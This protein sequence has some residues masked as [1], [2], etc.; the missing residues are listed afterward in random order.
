MNLKKHLKRTAIVVIILGILIAAN[1]AYPKINETVRSEYSISSKNNKEFYLTAHRGLS[2]V[3]PENTDLAILEAGIAGYYAAEF[4][5][6][7]TKDGRW[8]LMHDKT[9]D[10]MTNGE[11]EVSSFTFDE[12]R[13]LTVDG[14]NRS[15][16]HPE[17]III[18]TLEEALA[19]CE[20]YSMRAMIEI[21]GGEPEDMASVLEII[22]SMNLQT[23]PLIID[24]NSDRLDA[25]R[26][27]DRDIELWYLVSKISDGDIEF[28]KEHNT[29][30]AFNHKKFANYKM[31]GKAKDEGIKLAAWTVDLLPAADIL[32]ALGVKYITT[33][34]ILP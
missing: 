1:I 19:V 26:E 16:K 13:K 5:I 9:V 17:N 30:L 2:S 27:L 21:K 11:G 28:A 33:N 15:A 8:V 12:I 22:D 18:N 10:R 34:R 14:G 31:I 29:A 20:N 24:F 25:I 7:L 23:E 4:D 3:A 6:S 32:I